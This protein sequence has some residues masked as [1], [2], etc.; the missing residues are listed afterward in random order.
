MLREEESF[1]SGDWNGGTEVSSLL[2]LPV[3]PSKGR[4][5]A[6]RVE[7]W[8]SSLGLRGATSDETSEAYHQNIVGVEAWKLNLVSKTFTRIDDFELKLSRASLVPVAH[9]NQV[10]DLFTNKRGAV[11]AKKYGI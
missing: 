9:P 3:S 11:E 5:L 1:L 4:E 10:Y 7:I 2:V 8:L 6:D